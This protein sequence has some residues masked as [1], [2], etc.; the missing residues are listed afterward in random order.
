MFIIKIGKLNL[1]FIFLF[2]QCFKSFS[3]IVVTEIKAP[4][5]KTIPIKFKYDSLNTIEKLRPIGITPGFNEKQFIGIEVFL[6]NGNMTSKFCSSNKLV[7]YSN[8]NLFIE[9]VFGGGYEEQR[10][11]YI[12]NT[13]LET[14]I[15][16]LKDRKTNDSFFVSM[17][18]KNYQNRFV[19]VPFLIKMKELFENQYL[20]SQTNPNNG[21]DSEK[22]IITGEPV[23][24]LY[25]SV[26]LCNILVTKISPSDVYELYFI[27]KNEKNQTIA[28]PAVRSSI[29]SNR[30]YTLFLGNSNDFIFYPKNQLK[31]INDYYTQTDNRKKQLQDSAKSKED[32]KQAQLTKSYVDSYGEKIGKSIASGKVIIGMTKKMCQMAWGKPNNINKITTV[33]KEIETWTY[34]L[35]RKLYFLNGYLNEVNE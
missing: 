22:D 15:W 5:K 28:F 32:I 27:L 3:Q 2:L 18:N 17:A 33:S 25:K 10:D 30:F 6:P 23:K 35:Y 20:I 34:S 29:S 4:E 7:D 13:S 14:P 8:K 24:V 31:T 9:N 12:N 16:L 26:W 19:T 1:F 21:Y 11:M